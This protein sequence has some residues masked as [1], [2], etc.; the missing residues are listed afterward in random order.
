MLSL[1]PL[2]A[3]AQQAPRPPVQ[4]QV[5]PATTSATFSISTQLVVEKV[6]VKDKTG[7]VIEGLHKEDFSIT[8][9][10]KPQTIR[11]FD[12]ENIDQAP[13]AALPPLPAPTILPVPNSLKPRSRPNPRATSAT[14]IAA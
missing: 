2:L 3:Q 4:A 7:K 10:A 12:F 14:K 1:L 6:S 5:Q 13:A 9:D 11:F 8:E